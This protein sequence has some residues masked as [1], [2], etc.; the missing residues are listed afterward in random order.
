MQYEQ[1]RKLDDQKNS[2]I[3]IAGHDL[4]NLIGSD[5]NEQ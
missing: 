5:N 2:F 4:K 3:N 1:L